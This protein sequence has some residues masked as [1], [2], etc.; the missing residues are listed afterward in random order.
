[1]LVRLATPNDLSDLLR[2]YRQLTGDEADSLWADSNQAKALFE[3]IAVQP[4]RDLLVAEVDGMVVGTLDVLIVPNLS[5]GGAP[6]GIVE[7]VVVDE[8]MRGRGLGHSLME[9]AVRRC[10]DAGCYKVQLLTHK[11]RTRA[12][13]FYRSMEFEP[14]AEG[15]RRYLA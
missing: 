8:E 14:V 5:H 3:A 7:N 6:W 4:G 12:H 13:E 2:L 1:M 9:E 10:N 11:S 15:F